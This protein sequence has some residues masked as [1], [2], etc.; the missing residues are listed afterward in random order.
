MGIDS[1]LIRLTL[2]RIKTVRPVMR[3]ELRVGNGLEDAPNR[4]RRCAARRLKIA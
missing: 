4:M 3:L 2:I 1:I